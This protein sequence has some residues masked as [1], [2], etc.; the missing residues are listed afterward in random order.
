MPPTTQLDLAPAHPPS[1]PPASVSGTERQTRTGSVVGVLALAGISVSLM[2]TLVIP[3]VPQLPVLLG[4]TPSNTAWAVTATLLAGAVVTPIAGR[5]GD[6]LG[7]KPVLLASLV[8]MVVGSLLCAMADSLVPLV[9]GRVVQGLAAGVIPL[10]ISLMRDVLPPRKLGPAVALMSA[11]LGVGGA[12]GLPAAALIAEHA[13][14]HVLFWVSG[15]LGAIVLLLVLLLI[16]ARGARVGGR[17]DVGG[18][19]G[20]SITLVSLLL[21]VSKGA[22]WGWSTPR[23]LGLL[24]LALAAGAVWGWWQLR[25]SSPLVDL[26]TTARP[27]VLITNLASVVF[28]F[29]MFSMSLVIP[30]VV[31]L[32][33]ST[34]FGLGRSILVAG[35]VMV[36]SGL[37]MMIAAP[38]S[39]AVSRRTSSR[40]TLMIGAL[41]VAVGYALGVFFMGSVWQLC[42]VTGVIG[43]GIGFA[44]GS[45]PQLIMSAVPVS[46]TASANGFNTLVRSIGTSVSSAVAGAVLAA[47]ATIVGTVSIP[48]QG[49]FQTILVVGSVAALVTF[50]IAAFLPRQVVPAVGP[51]LSSPAGANTNSEGF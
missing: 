15:G 13:D 45:L 34:G 20:L 19:L 46:E 14:W 41:T 44:Y 50:I 40:V 36:P 33:A 43:A 32:P 25:T 4:S 38:L 49:G 11:S 17:L 22:E 24:A 3:I 28:G 12:L 51:H 1:A 27:Q 2:Q 26:R 39:A 35:L 18:A 48:S 7:K 5:L 37:V 10:G 6:M 16:P 8:A 21:A 42:V 23:T 31:Q 30:Q 29:S 9:V 47:S